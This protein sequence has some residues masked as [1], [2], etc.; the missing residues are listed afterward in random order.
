MGESV[1]KEQDEKFKAES[2]L[3]SGSKV[4]KSSVSGPHC[5]T[6]PPSGKDRFYSGSSRRGWKREVEMENDRARQREKERKRS[7]ERRKKEENHRDR[8]EEQS[9]RKRKDDQGKSPD[10]RPHRCSESLPAPS[11]KCKGKAAGSPP[12]PPPLHPRGRGEERGPLPSEGVKESPTDVTGEKKARTEKS[13]DDLINV[14]RP[15][16]G[17]ARRPSEEEKKG[18]RRRDVGGAVR[19]EPGPTERP[20]SPSAS[21]GSSGGNERMKDAKHKKEKGEGAPELLEE[22]EKERKWKKSRD[23]REN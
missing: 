15:Q 8:E 11:H 9:E 6:A 3:G 14:C 23:G 10:S 18:R 21:R 4:E 7:Q 20:R 1:K 12:S 2:S 13:T 22:R 16:G 17:G 19:R 5:G